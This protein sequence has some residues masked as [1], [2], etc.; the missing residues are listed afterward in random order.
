MATPALEVLESPVRRRI[1]DLLANLPAVADGIAEPPGL[2][3]AQVAAEIGMH[4]T[5]ARFHLDL[6]VRRELLEAI[7]RRG[8]VGRPR[9]VYRMRHRPQAAGPDRTETARDELTLLLAE[10]WHADGDRPAPSA[11]EAG[12]RWAREHAPSLTEAERLTARTPG[13]WLGKVGRT[14]D[15]LQL[16]GYLPEVRTT[17]AGRTAELTL[18]DCPFLTLAQAHPDVVCGIHRGLLRGALHAVGE[19]E[20][21]VGLQPF[22]GPTT[23][24]AWITTRA[25]FAA[26]TPGGA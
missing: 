9:K 22:V 1:V 10:T 14:V 11:E 4:V 25:A 24:R 8:G 18:V 15:L 21:E 7:F 17:D 19:E 13:A 5:T 12:E 20:T 2:T 6:L 16:W 3:A 26:S 23:C